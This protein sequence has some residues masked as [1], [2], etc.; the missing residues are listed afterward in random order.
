M[1]SSIWPNIADIIGPR[2]PVIVVGNKVDLL[3]RDTDGHLAHVR[4][5]LERAV[6][7]QGIDAT[8]IK[9]TCL[10]S[11]HTGFGVEELITKLHN[12]WSYRGDVYLL[13]CTN[14]GKSTL[15]NALL[16]SDYCKSQASSLIGRATASPW[17][18]TTMRMLKF[19][20]MRPNDWRLYLRTKRIVSQRGQRA[21]E[22][23][24]RRDQAEQHRHRSE[25]ATLIGHIDQTFRSESLVEVS[26]AFGMGTSK[27]GIAETLNERSKQF[28]TSK[29]CFDTP[30]VVQPEQTLNLLTTVEL[31]LAIPRRMLVPRTFRLQPGWTLFVA[32]LGRVDLV[33]GGSAERTTEAAVS[34]VT[35]YA[36]DRL[37][38][39]IVRTVD[40]ERVYSRFLGTEVLAV[41]HTDDEADSDGRLTRWPA[42]AGKTIDVVGEEDDIKQTRGAAVCDIVLSSAGWVG[43]HARRGERLQFEVW[44]P[45]GRGIVQRTPALV[46]FGRQLSGPRVRGSLAHQNRRAFV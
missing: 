1:P 10:I 29:W 3:P 9:H 37:P 5:A 18:G 38:V 25:H 11:A 26:D 40:A 21:A 16:R 20:I 32:G 43:V 19:P 36:S 4:A 7:A 34:L 35:V 39:L 14:V 13:G 42:L 6:A 12:V 28:V 8:N 31:L 33:S 27:R 23:R 45:Q 2:R 22:L 17:P 30:G 15:F 24:L 41:P 44:T 46:P